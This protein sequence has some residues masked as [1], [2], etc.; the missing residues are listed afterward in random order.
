MDEFAATIKPYDG[1]V[2]D[3]VSGSRQYDDREADELE[4]SF[5]GVDGCNIFVKELAKP[6]YATIANKMGLTAWTNGIR[7]KHTQGDLR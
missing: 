1:N 2:V 4:E 5:G 3:Y 7:S 6:K